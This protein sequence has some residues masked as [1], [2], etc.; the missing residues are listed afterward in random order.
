LT[1][2]ISARCYGQ[3]RPPVSVK[4]DSNYFPPSRRR[5]RWNNKRTTTI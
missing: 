3:H 1:V 2:K 4:Y 5:R